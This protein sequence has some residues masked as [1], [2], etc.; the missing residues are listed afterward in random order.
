MLNSSNPIPFISRSICPSHDSKSFSLVIL[1]P[2]FVHIPRRPCELAISS[3]F[4]IHILPFIL[5]RGTLLIPPPLALAMLQS[6]SELPDIITAVAPSILPMTFRLPI[7]I[8]PHISITIREKNISPLSMLESP[9]PLPFIPI[10]IAPH[11]HAVPIRPRVLPLA[12]IAVPIDSLP[13][14]IAVLQ[15]VSPLPIVGLP[16]APLVHAVSVCFAFVKPADVSVAVGV[17]LVAHAVPQV[18]EEVAFVDPFVF[19]LHDAL[20]LALACLWVHLPEV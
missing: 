10:P 13:H 1:I 3:L 15:P 12:N 17:L 2:S 16:V 14:A 7:H 4:I 5:I 20:A 6:T 19:V 11:M 18:L 8:L 9:L